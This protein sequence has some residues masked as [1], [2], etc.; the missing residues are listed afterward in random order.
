[1]RLGFEVSASVQSVVVRPAF[2]WGTS[3]DLRLDTFAN[4]WNEHAVK[5]RL[6]KSRNA[7]CIKNYMT[8]LVGKRNATQEAEA[9]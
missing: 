3:Q 5:Q 9:M 7:G 2:L 4:S 6:T 1:M 8:S